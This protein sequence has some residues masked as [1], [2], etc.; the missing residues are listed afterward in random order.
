MIEISKENMAL[1]HFYNKS[2]E[3]VFKDLKK[4]DR[5]KFVE[6]LTAKI[7]ACLNDSIFRIEKAEKEKEREVLSNEFKKYICKIQESGD[8]EFFIKAFG[9]TLNKRYANGNEP[10]KILKEDSKENSE[11]DFQYWMKDFLNKNS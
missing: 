7:C 10:D 2:F 3:K 4:E 6:D 9:E 1:F 11:L 8:E 5:V